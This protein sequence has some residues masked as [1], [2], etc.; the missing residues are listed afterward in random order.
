MKLISCFGCGVVLN[1]DHLC[2]PKDIDDEEGNIDEKKAM[3]HQ[4]KKEFIPFIEC[5]V[6]KEPIFK[7]D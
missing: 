7:E 5:P 1:H 4:Q 2:F 3:Y 6:C